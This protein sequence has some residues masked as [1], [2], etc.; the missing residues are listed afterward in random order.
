M[1]KYKTLQK[2]KK[3]IEHG[4]TLFMERQYEYYEN[5]YTTESNLYIQCNAQ[6]NPNISL[7][8]NRKINLKNYVER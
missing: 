7:H 8:K 3:T 6:Q 1:K 4:K 2:L 5:G